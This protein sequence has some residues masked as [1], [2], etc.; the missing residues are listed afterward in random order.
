MKGGA[1]GVKATYRAVKFTASK[2]AVI[3]VIA[4]ANSARTLQITNG[5]KVVSSGDVGSTAKAYTYTAEADG[6]YYVY[7]KSSAMN[8][9]AITVSG[10]S[11]SSS[12]S[13]SSGSSTSTF[14]TITFNADNLSHGTFTANTNSG[15]FTVYATSAKTVS[16]PYSAVT[17]NGTTFKQKLALGGGGSY[18][19]YRA[20]G[21]QA[22]KGCTVTVYAA[23]AAGRYLGLVKSDGSVESKK[24]VSSSAAVY[25]F[26][27]GSAGWY[28]IM[29]TGSGIDIYYIKVSK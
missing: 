25:T 13:S 21:F 11:S 5:S 7:S 10:T 24:E 27:T 14:S 20:V 9:Y 4:N 2:G 19:T 29:S 15:S 6:T 1:D 8:L 16:T 23:G 18:N 12:G 17:V 26:T 3:T 28:N 22:E